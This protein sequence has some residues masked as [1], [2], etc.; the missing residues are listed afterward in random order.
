MSLSF[1]NESMLQAIVENIFV[2]KGIGN[3]YIS[4]ELKYISLIGL[5][6]NQ[7]VEFGAN[8][9]ENLISKR[10]VAN[11]SSSGVFDERIDSNPNKLKGFVILVIALCKPIEEV[12]SNYNYNKSTFSWKD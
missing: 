4:L 10:K 1:A 12:I 7:K 9:L 8:E 5:I 2:L 11:Y 6:K 3:N